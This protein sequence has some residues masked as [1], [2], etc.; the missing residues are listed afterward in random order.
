[1]CRFTNIFVLTAGK[2]NMYKYLIHLFLFTLVNKLPALHH[3]LKLYRLAESMVC[4][5]V[6]IIM[7]DQV[8]LYS[9][10]LKHEDSTPPLL[11]RLRLRLTFW[12]IEQDGN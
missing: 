4:F 1:M 10:G 6:I 7:K 12:P 11:N 5:L 3:F 2:S 9:K 8:I